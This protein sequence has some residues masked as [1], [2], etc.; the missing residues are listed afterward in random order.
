MTMR[1][2]LA[3]LALVLVLAWARVA[4]AEGYARAAADA[5]SA[6]GLAPLDDTTVAKIS[7][8][9]V[10]HPR[11]AEPARVILWDEE[12]PAK[13]NLSENR[14]QTF[15]PIPDPASQQGPSCPA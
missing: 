9:G 8:R 6:W 13:G 10:A 15:V 3:L 14:A 12:P 7:G 2:A 4:F 1:R 11:S 5:D